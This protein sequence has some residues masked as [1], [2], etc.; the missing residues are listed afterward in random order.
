MKRTVIVLALI[1]L[2]LPIVSA[3]EGKR[4]STAWYYAGETITVNNK[5]YSLMISSA[6][7]KIGL[8]YDSQLEIIDV[9]SCERITD[10]GFCVLEIE[11]YEKEHRRRAR[12]EVYDLETA[13]EV[14]REIENANLIVGEEAEMTVKIENNGEE[15]TIVTYIDEFP[16]GIEITEADKELTVVGN[17]VE[18]TGEIKEGRDEEFEYSIR[19]TQKTDST[20]VGRFEYDGEAYFTDKL[21]LTAGAVLDVKF[22]WEQ[23]EIPVGYEID[24]DVNLSN[25]EDDRIRVNNFTIIFPEGLIVRKGFRRITNYTWDGSISAGSSKEISFHVKADKSGGFRVKSMAEFEF[26]EKKQLISRHES[27]L[28]VGEPQLKIWIGFD[29]GDEELNENEIEARQTGYIEVDVQKPNPDVIIK[30]IKIEISIPYINFTKT[31]YFDEIEHDDYESKRVANIKFVA[32]DVDRNTKIKIYVTTYYETEFGEKNQETEDKEIKVLKI[33][34]VKITN[35]VDRTVE[36]GDELEVKI[37][38]ENKR[39]EMLEDVEVCDGNNF[40]SVGKTCKKLSIPKETEITVFAY[41]F[42][43]PRVNETTKYYFNTSISYSDD[44]ESYNYSRLTTVS[45]KPRTLELKITKTLEDKQIYVGEPILVDYKLRND[46]EETLKDVVLHFGASQYFE[47]VGP[48]THYVGNIDPDETINLYDIA[49]IRAKINDTRVN[50]PVTKATFFDYYFGRNFTDKSREIRV[51][52]NSSYVKGPLMI[53]SKTVNTSQVKQS[54]NFTVT[55]TVKNEGDAVV[56]ITVIDNGIEKTIT[57]YTGNAVVMK[58][59]MS[60]SEAGPQN[61]PVAEATYSYHDNDYYAVSNEP[62]I[63]VRR[64]RVEVKEGEELD[65][66]AIARAVEEARQAQKP[67]KRTVMKQIIDF[68]KGLF[69]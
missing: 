21:R 30:N 31:S 36:S 18:W 46:E 6:N 25:N 61:L 45:I 57:P 62:N 48:R 59:N 12:I 69:S 58:Y 34:E 29:I 35:D 40:P 64:V 20:L 65:E 54:Q 7:D 41:K 56:P 22:N 14:T 66:E 17:R 50:V 5:L 27:T 8:K 11:D 42:K 1:L 10:A 24:L 16:E 32:P 67:K 51:K 43:T 38:L 3:F 2:I 63:N 47:I 52:V 39:T 9:G 13:I 53:L 23:Q 55:V 44:F 19:A 28:E 60:L 26:G 37:K 33:K 15:D 49:T 4:I 68:F